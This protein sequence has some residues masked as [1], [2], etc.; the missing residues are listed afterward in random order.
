VPFGL[1]TGRGFVALGIVAGGLPI[2][3]TSA[4]TRRHRRASRTKSQPIQ[5]PSR[6]RLG[7]SDAA[8]TGGRKSA[9]SSRSSPSDS[10]SASRMF[11]VVELAGE[12]K[13]KRPVERHRSFGPRTPRSR[14]SST[15]LR[16]KLEKKVADHSAL[17]DNPSFGE[18][19][20]IHGYPCGVIALFLGLVQLG[21]SLRA[22]SRVLEFIARSFDLPFSAPDWT[23]GRMWLLRFGLAQLNA[24]K[25]RAD[26]WVWLIDHSVQIGNQ[27]ILVILGIRLVD[28]PSAGNWLR[29]EDMALIALIPMDTSTR[30]DVAKRLADAATRTGVPCTIVDDHGVDLNGGVR[31]FQQNHP[32]TVEI[33]DVKHKAACLLKSR[34]EKNPRWMAFC[35]RVGQARCAIQQTKLGALTP[36]SSQLK[37]RFMNL[38]DQLNW[39]DK[40][41]ALLDGLP[42]SALSWMTPQRLEEKLGWMRE[43]RDDLSEWRQWQAI[44]DMTVNFVGSEGLHGKTALTLNRKLRP[45]LRTAEGRRLAV[46]LVKFVRGE[47]SKAKPG[48]RLPG[49][50]EVLE[51]CFGKF[52]TLEKDQSKGGFTSLLLGFGA[53]FAEATNEEVLGA[54]QAES[55]R[56]IKDWCAE[57]IGQTLFSRRKEAF[58]MARTAQQKLAEPI[59]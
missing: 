21:V 47:A 14:L 6:F 28:L 24:L 34:L 43:F 30:E 39:A 11:A 36:P 8:A 42:G 15:H 52:K 3:E 7:S 55:T 41:L 10:A 45:L 38:A 44:M 37:A 56:Q 12:A 20:A 2:T 23:T 29:S 40:I 19:P 33:Y 59:L 58:D 13:P 32:D 27:K 46:E 53:L 4:W 57:H 5:L 49:S 17:V 35:T 26:D 48:E 9:W 1:T 51:S 54:M 25:I 18:I 50:T 31:I 22:T 16:T